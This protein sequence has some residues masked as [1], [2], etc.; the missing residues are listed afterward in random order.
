[1]RTL[2]CL[3]L[4]V[5]LL[6]GPV[7]AAQLYRWVDDKG[8]VEYR[9]TP[10]PANAKK[11]E[12]RDVSG[13]TIETS[14]LPYSV[15]Q[16]VKKHPVTLWVYDCGDPC[17]KARAHLVKRGVPHTERNPQKEPD[18]MKK[19]TGGNDVPVLFVGSNQLKGYLDTAWDAA[20]DS[21]GYPKSP[22]PGYKPPSQTSAQ[23]A[24]DAKG[25]TP[26]RAAEGGASPAAK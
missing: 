4:A 22:P 1:M 6:A 11:V 15:Q 16:A 13:N 17:V 24:A 10:P 18:A 14:G 26:Q 12:R 25:K 2:S 8:N 3:A 21:A 9:D 19:A 5:A 7:S 23:P 20:L